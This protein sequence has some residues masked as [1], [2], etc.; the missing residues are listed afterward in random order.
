MSDKVF[1]TY[2]QQRQILENRGLIVAHP[3]FFTNCMQRDDYYS[4]IN[5]HKRYFLAGTSP[6]R[7]LK[8]T[9]FEQIYAL[10]MFD[11]T[12]SFLFLDES[13][14][15]EKHIKSLIA[16]HFSE[17]HGYDHRQYLDVNCFKHS[18]LKNRQFATD[19][20]SRLEKDISRNARHGNEA[21]CHYLEHYGYVPLWVLNSVLTFGRIAHFYSCMNLEEQQAIAKHFNMSA[22]ELD[23]FIYFLN[24]LRNTCAH[25]SR[26]YT[27]NTAKKYQKII[28]DTRIH[29]LLKI[30]KNNT[31]NYISG[32]TDVLAIFITLKYFSK[33]SDFRIIKKKFRKAYQ[34]MASIVPASVLKNIN[35][36]MG[37]PA[38]YLPML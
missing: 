36:E 6:E 29:D 27:T 12:I 15:I 22:S 16:Y 35:Q 11:R 20:I 5:G 31:G 10:Y 1:C 9:S 30:P 4:I 32:K 34:K 3:R 37:F 24:D 25:G 18:S 2:Q 26:I 28:P 14:K 17:K 7:Y 21:I 38:T 19:L 8:E 33:K 23:G 13:I